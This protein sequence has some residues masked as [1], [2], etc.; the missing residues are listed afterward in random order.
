MGTIERG[1][2]SLADGQKLNEAMKETAE[3]LEIIVEAVEVI[4][5]ARTINVK[6][7][8]GTTVDFTNFSAKPQGGAGSKPEILKG[9]FGETTLQFTVADNVSAFEISFVE[10][11]NNQPYTM[12]VAFDSSVKDG[13]MLTVQF[14]VNET[15]QEIVYSQMD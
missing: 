10:S 13:D 8:N 9:G 2:L 12:T 5:S 1:G 3:A 4:P 6:F 7:V 14:N 15:T 11:A